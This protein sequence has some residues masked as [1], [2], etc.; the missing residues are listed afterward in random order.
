MSAPDLPPPPAHPVGP[1]PLHVH[2][3]VSDVELRVL[4]GGVVVVIDAI[5]ASVTIAAALAAGAR[6]VVPVLS[7]AEAEGR[8]AALRA[9]GVAVVCGGERGGV[10]VPGFELDNSPA[11]YTSDRVAGRT[12]VF[13][14]T[15]GTAALLHAASAERV[16]VGSFANLVAVCSAVEPDPRPVHLLC[17]G[18]RDEVSLDDVLP[19]GAMADRLVAAGRSLTGDDGARLAML[20]WRGA[21]DDLEGAMRSSRGGRNLITQGLGADVTACSRRDWLEVV[22]EYDRVSGEIRLADGGRK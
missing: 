18:T 1:R 4:A 20:A 11:S 21:K 16:L 19:A 2:L 12:V 6:A 17:C 7:V 9:A 8:A 15:N 22:P 10:R 13:T 14:T 3:H 5:R